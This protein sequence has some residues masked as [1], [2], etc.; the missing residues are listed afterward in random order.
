MNTT[1]PF[2]ASIVI[3]TIQLGATIDYAIL[4]SST[5]LEERL[6]KNKNDAMK[7]TLEKTI[8]SIIV[9]ALCFFAATFGVAFYSK[10]DMIASICDLL[11]RGS[12]ISMLTVSLILPALLLAFDKL[13]IKTTSGMKGSLK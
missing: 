3:G 7:H 10:I 4:L 9:S 1:L 2:I 13:I 8:P 6:T 11:S 5:Y 12:I